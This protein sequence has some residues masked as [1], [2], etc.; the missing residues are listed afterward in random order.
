MT[1]FSAPAHCTCILSR[2]RNGAY[3]KCQYHRN[4]IDNKIRNRFPSGMRVGVDLTIEFKIGFEDF[5]AYEDW[6]QGYVVSHIDPETGDRL[7]QSDQ[8]L[9]EAIEKFLTKP[10]RTKKNPDPR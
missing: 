10:Y 4:P 6:G 9:D 8:Y 1:A 3:F 7:W 5:G 2:T